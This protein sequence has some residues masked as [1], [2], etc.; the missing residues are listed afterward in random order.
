MYGTRSAV[1]NGSLAT[2]RTGPVD[3]RDKP[4]NRFWINK[5]RQPMN[6]SVQAIHD[7]QQRHLHDVWDK[8]V[9]PTCERERIE[10]ETGQ[11][12]LHL[13]TRRP[14]RIVHELR[15]KH[16]INGYAYDV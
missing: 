12:E 7:I 4:T 13:L 1:T 3:R 15:R 9:T 6:K 10:H 11:N 14:H 5:E 2:V 16:T 8:N